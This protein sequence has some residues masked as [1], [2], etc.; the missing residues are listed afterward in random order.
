M[1]C[2]IDRSSIT[3]VELTPLR[4][5]HYETQLTVWVGGNNYDY[6]GVPFNISIS[7]M[8]SLPSVRE[9]ENGYHT[10]EGMDHVESKE[11]LLIAE[12]ILEKL[13]Q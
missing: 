4:G 12:A 3:K 2:K 13:L 1:S 7:G 9:L 5:K 8:G 10:D 6:E 11:H